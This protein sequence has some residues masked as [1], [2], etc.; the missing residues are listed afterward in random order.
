MVKR[1]KKSGL[2]TF[3]AIELSQELKNAF[4]STQESLIEEG[5]FFRWVKP[6]NIHLTMKFLGEIDKDLLPLID[7]TVSE[8]CLGNETFPIHLKGLGSFKRK[9][10]SAVIWAG[11]DECL[12]LNIL[13]SQLE[14]SLTPLGFA[15]EGR[16]VPHLTLG[17]T[18]ALDDRVHF[19]QTLEKYGDLNFGTMTVS[20]LSLIKSELKPEGPVY[21]RLY[22]FP[23]TEES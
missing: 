4:K 8:V 6:Q 14:D 7:K 18:K 19:R 23:F 5:L 12:P 10:G 9:G 20:A 13:H 11:I 22:H 3:I 2:R 17:R 16:F 21:T 1:E 15:Q